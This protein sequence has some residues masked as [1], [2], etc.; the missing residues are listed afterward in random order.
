MDLYYGSLYWST[1]ET[2]E[3]R[4]A[5]REPASRYDAVIVGGGMSGALTAYTLAAEGMT[6]AVLDKGGMASGSSMANSGL[7]QFSNDTMLHRLMQQIGKEEA[8]RFYRLCEEAVGKLGLIA[9]SLDSPTD[10]IRRN[11]LYYASEDAD[12]VLVQ[13]EYAALRENGFKADYLTAEALAEQYPFV[14]PA[15]LI[16]YGDAELNP[17]R[18]VRAIL[19]YLDRKGVHFFEHTEVTAL[20]NKE[21]HIIVHTVKGG[22]IAQNAIIATGYA[23]PPELPYN[24]ADLN[25][26]YVIATQPLDDLDKVWKDRVLIWETR[27][28]CFYL[29]TT[30]DGRIVAGGMD[31]DKPE[32]PRSKELIAQRADKLKQAVE[33]LFPMLEIQVAYAWG[34]V[35]GESLDNLP[36]IGRHPDRE[37]LYYLLG[38]GGNGIVYSMLGAEII[39]D[40][41]QGKSNPDAKLLQL[42]RPGL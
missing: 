19:T 39:R 23:P 17:F 41:I 25:R 27:R 16:T 38:Y 11:S 31:E 10:F 42:A 3:L 22:F 37:R 36:F 35:F 1:T 18:F 26:S 28:P 33:R 29:R 14:K 7:I 30:A 6:V 24:G 20:E 12:A 5:P 8:V 34:A 13:K 2:E 32:A 21:D 15:A 40:L 4:L 9:R